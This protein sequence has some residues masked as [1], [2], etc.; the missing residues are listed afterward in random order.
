M[1]GPSSHLLFV[2]DETDILSSFKEF[3]ESNIPG[4]TVHT[5][6][7]GDQALQMLKKLAKVDLIISDYKMPGM[8][9]ITFLKQAEGV[10]P[11]T[12]KVLLTAFP[13]LDLAIE[14]INEVRVDKF[15]TKPLPPDR[16]LDVVR[17]LLGQGKGFNFKPAP[18]T[19]PPGFKLS[20]P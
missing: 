3:L 2:D 17:G 8:D 11:Q 15:L 6:E 18:P 13:K 19:P 1:P 9:G 20:R 10:V 4:L 12:P 7:N 14:A 16:L 5:A